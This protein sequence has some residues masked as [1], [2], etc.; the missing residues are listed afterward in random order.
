MYIGEISPPSLRGL[1]SAVPQISL[2]VGV[3]VVYC[4]GWIRMF[5]FQ[6]TAI[7]AVGITL[8]FLI[9]VLWV[10]ETPRYLITKG[11]RTD[12]AKSL[13]FLRGPHVDISGEVYEI[14]VIL[15][16]DRRFE[17]V[18]EFLYELRKKSS[19]ISFLLL[20]FL[21]AIQQL[22][23]INALIFYA[24][25]VLNSAGVGHSQF[26]A[27][28]C[29]GLTEVVATVVSSLVVDLFGRKILLISSAV[30]MS[31]SCT[32]LGVHF[33]FSHMAVCNEVVNATAS[34]GDT[35]GSGGC[36]HLSLLAVVSVIGF[37]VGYSVGMGAIPWIL[38][39]ELFPLR[40]RGVLAG[41]VSAVNWACAAMVAGLY[42]EY[43]D[44]VKEWC[45]WWTF[46]MLNLIAAVFVAVLLPETRGKK[47]ELIEQQLLYNYR[48]CSWR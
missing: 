29:I 26:T 23:G 33:Y 28:L 41:V 4:V 32:A 30:V 45:A 38:I 44:L 14:E 43:V 39:S 40:V 15:S 37:M 12:A 17:S 42:F 46:A 48:L 34:I 9:L 19:Y 22:S 6:Y 31:L 1:F 20:L 16:K 21:L 5:T 18:R 13:K 27:L 3:L 25:N 8:V 2:A 7:L 35:A 10:P 24:A 11:K 47:L 36:P